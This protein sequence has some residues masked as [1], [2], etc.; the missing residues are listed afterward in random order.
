MFQKV[1][2]QTQCVSYRFMYKSL[3]L[4]VLYNLAIGQPGENAC[5]AIKKFAMCVPI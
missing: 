5:H 4:M 2:V 1:P 3:E